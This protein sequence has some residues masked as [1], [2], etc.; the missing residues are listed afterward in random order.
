MNDLIFKI[1]EV[2]NLIKGFRAGYN[3]KTIDDGKFLIEYCG[4]RFFVKMKKVENPSASIF[5]DVDRLKY[6]D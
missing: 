3:T 4:E 2:L 5:D 6:F 1:H